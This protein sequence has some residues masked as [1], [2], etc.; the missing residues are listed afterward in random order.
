MIFPSTPE[1][2]SHRIACN[3]ALSYNLLNSKCMED[4]MRIAI[5]GA[6]YLVFPLPMRSLRRER[7]GYKG[8]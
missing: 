3:A 7:L 2:L 4:L 8:F 1:L 5:V 6:V